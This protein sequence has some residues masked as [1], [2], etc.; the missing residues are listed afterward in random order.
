MKL[1]KVSFVVLCLALFAASISYSQTDGQR[2]EQVRLSD[3]DWED[4]MAR[5]DVFAIALN[6][7]ANSTGYIIF[8]GSRRSRRGEIQRRM[9][10]VENYMVQRR[11][12]ASNRI[13]VINGGYRDNSTMELWVVP[14][15]GRI[16]EATP[17]I[18]SIRLRRGTIRFT[19]EV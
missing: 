14:Q 4:N 18:R 10:C 3:Y 5:L 15:G 7:E 8:Y 9:T 19:C 11:G 6:N 16:P 12:I 2:L 13:R 1:A 17:T